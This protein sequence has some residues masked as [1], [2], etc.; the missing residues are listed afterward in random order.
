MELE[1]IRLEAARQLG[2]GEQVAGAACSGDDCRIERAVRIGEPRKLLPQSPLEHRT[3]VVELEGDSGR[4]ERREERVIDAVGA[5]GEAEPLEATKLRPGQ[6]ARV[7]A[8][9]ASGD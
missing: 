6:E 5:D 2:D 7:R 8:A 1:R 9:D 3:R 4:R